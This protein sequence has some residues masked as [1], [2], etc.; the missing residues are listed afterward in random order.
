MT[1]H[2]LR[3]TARPGW[4]NMAVDAALLDLAAE[5]GDAFLR[6]YRWEPH[7]LSFGRHEPALRRYDVERIRALGLDVVRRP[8]GGRA[9]WHAGELTYA[10]AAPLVPFGGQ[11][12]AYAAIH[13]VIAEAIRSLG[14]DSALAEPGRALS[15]GAGPCFSAPVGGEVLIGGKKVTG[16]AQL[17]QGDTLLQHGSILLEDDQSLVRGLAGQG[18]DEP[19]EASLSQALGRM[20]GIEELSLAIAAAARRAFGPMT[21]ISA[22]SNRIATHLPRHQA[23][24]RDLAWTWQR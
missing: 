14:G 22:D 21:P 9:V 2:L 24:F 6:L 11:K 19:A 10:V 16:S 13:A 5:G 12:P 23:R 20:V 17:I 4:Q 7:C 15:P 3:D 8:T 18:G 1:W